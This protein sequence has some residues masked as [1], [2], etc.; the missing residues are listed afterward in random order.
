MSP[1]WT[2]LALM[3][4]AGCDVSPRL[5][6]TV[7]TEA[8]STVDQIRV[9]VYSPTRGDAD[10]TDGAVTPAIDPA[11]P[12]EMRLLGRV[13]GERVRVTVDGLTA[14]VRRIHQEW[15]A[16]MPSEGAGYLQ[17]V[18]WNNCQDV[19]CV[20]PNTTCSSTGT[21]VPNNVGTLPMT[22]VD[23]GLGFCADSTTGA[24][25]VVDASVT[26]AAVNDLGGSSDRPAADVPDV[27]LVPDVPVVVDAADASAVVDAADVP[28]DAVGDVVADAPGDA[29]PDAGRCPGP[30]TSLV[31]DWRACADGT[32]CPTLCGPA[33]TCLHAQQ[34][35]LGRDFACAL[36]SDR[37]VSCF[38][39][40][41][42]GHLGDN[43]ADGGVAP[44]PV[45]VLRAV[46]HFPFRPVATLASGYEGSCATDPD[47]G[48]SCWGSINSDPFGSP[49]A[50]VYV[51]TPASRLL[52]ADAGAAAN[53]FE[54]A[55]THSTQT[56]AVVR[57]GSVR[58]SSWIRVLADGS[59]EVISNPADYPVTDIVRVDGTLLTGVVEVRVG[60]SHACGRLGDGTVWC[61]GSNR[62]AQLGATPPD[63]DGGGVG[64]SAARAVPGISA[65]TSLGVGD[66]FSC[67]L[68]GGDVRC[69]GDASNGRVGSYSAAADCLDG[70]SCAPVPT[71]VAGLAELAA[72]Y[73][74]TVAQVAVGAEEAC[75]RLAH[76]EVWCWGLNDVGQIGLPTTGADA[77]SSRGGVQGMPVFTGADDIVT[78][79][80][81]GGEGHSWTCARRASDC[82]WWCWGYV[83]GE[84]APPADR[85]TPRLLRWGP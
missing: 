50:P 46:T 55:S 26:D 51:A 20:D 53:L 3:L 25:R 19:V 36:R 65:A 80:G 76:G 79:G 18:L 85:G 23:A 81:G 54:G 32:W 27:P 64:S 4:V 40:R 24:C 38:G 34:L 6:L 62:Y 78:G 47:G 2:A 17:I 9:Q 45:E 43:V 16:S 66:V 42:D 29:P 82:T 14:G 83:P 59:P 70:N 75:A 67:A 8:G 5:Y 69:W 57:G 68:M 1:R 22:A 84:A 48:L 52:R 49:Y 15:V 63:G 44:G 30:S 71:S 11:H 7:R 41:D 37:G 12:F 28:A 60:S 31:A 10:L 74:S 73:H 72:A 35:S 21:C 13:G 77:V 61:W 33:G 39:W 56:C 58:C